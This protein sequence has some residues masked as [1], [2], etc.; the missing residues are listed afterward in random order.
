MSHAGV[1]TERR[2]RSSVR[3]KKREILGRSESMTIKRWPLTI[4]QIEG[5]FDL[6][7]NRAIPHGEIEGEGLKSKDVI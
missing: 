5:V 2:K 7:W 3:Q 1:G 4:E 6:R